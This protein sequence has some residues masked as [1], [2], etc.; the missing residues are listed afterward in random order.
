MTKFKQI[1][2]TNINECVVAKTMVDGI[3]VLA[4]NRDRGYDAKVKIIHEL[5]DGV[6]V[7]YLHDDLTDWSEGLNEFGVGI[8]NA[9]LTVGFDEKEGD[10]AKKKLD[11][12]KAPK[13][14]HDGLKIRTALSKKTLL[15]TIR[16]VITF[17]GD[18]NKSVGIKGHTIVANPKH[19]FAI[20]MTSKDVPIIKRLNKN[21][22]TVRTNH[23][24]E[25]K[26]AGYGNGVKRK[27]SISRLTIAK[28][29]LKNAKSPNEVLD[30]LSNQ[31]TKDPFMN[32]YRRDNKHDM[33]TTAQV[34]YNLNNLEFHLRWDVGHSTYGGVVNRLP[35]KYEPK[36]KIF[37]GI[38]K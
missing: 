4:K 9:S 20:E 36:I 26:T 18:D 13:V 7:V 10:I 38:S 25:Y 2:S 29:K 3:T 31:Y 11:K 17:A 12:G 33:Q 15:D 8:V 30:I 34:M 23:G 37:V 24:V 22:T 16:S 27:S 21:G 28:D 1:I 19:V 6:E 14:S 35:Q 5:I 32:P